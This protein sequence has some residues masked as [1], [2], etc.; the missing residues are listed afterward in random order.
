MRRALVGTGAALLL[1][2]AAWLLLR[3]REPLPPGLSGAI[4][5]VSDRDGAPA[6]YWRRLPAGRARRLTTMADPAVEPALSPDGTRVAFAMGGRIALVPSSGGDAR[7]LTLAIDWHDAQPAWLPDGRRLVVSARRRAGEP[8]GLHLLTLVDDGR[9][10]ERAPLT[11]PSAGDD[12][13]PA[14]AP[15][16]A[17]IVFVREHHLM[18]VSLADGRVRRLTGGFKR[19]RSP[20]FLP[21]GR[22]VCAW[23]E[24]KRHGIDT[25]DAGGR[26]RRTL[27]EGG[28][29]YRTLVP[30]PDGRLL[31]A[32]LSWDSGGAALG[33][34]LGAERE[35]VRLLD[36]SGRDLAALE[37]S[38]RH[39]NHSP[40]W[41]R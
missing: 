21:G 17:S 13:S 16:G 33:A 26:G 12:T 10:V 36:L 1:A 7:V 5:F 22:I 28:R 4:V 6:L 8:A 23:S 37:R 18:A 32:T 39:G 35:Q 20:R 29:F 38:S 2:L 9:R 24:D 14:P 19:E 25:L 31:A 41:G 30:S 34:L 15:D 27:T 40:D 11:S 3:D